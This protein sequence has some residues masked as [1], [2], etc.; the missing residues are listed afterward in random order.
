MEEMDADRTLSLYLTLFV[1]EKERDRVGARHTQFVCK[2]GRGHVSSM[3]QSFKLYV[4]G[5]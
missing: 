5:M 3:K 1:T 4:L 2:R